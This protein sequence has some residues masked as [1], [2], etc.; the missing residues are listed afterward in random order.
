MNTY[1]E[2]MTEAR[3]RY[4]QQLMLQTGGKRVEMRR[5]C[6]LSRSKMFQEL[7]ELGFKPVRSMGNAAWQSLE[8]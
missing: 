8:K 3:R 6:G 7:R 5:I 4:W 2:A 1:A